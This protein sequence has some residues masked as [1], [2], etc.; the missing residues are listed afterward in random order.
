MSSF[1]FEWSS[2]QPIPDIVISTR[3]LASFFV[4]FAD[5]A[6]SVWHSASLTDWTMI[7]ADVFEMRRL[8]SIQ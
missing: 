4:G 3:F 2:T 5:F 8:K 6:V 7:M 1:P